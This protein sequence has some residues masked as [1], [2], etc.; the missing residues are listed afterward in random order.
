M[1]STPD[2]RRGYT[3]DVAT[4][5]FPLPHGRDDEGVLPRHRPVG[6]AL[7]DLLVLGPE[8]DALRPVLVDVAE[9]RALPAAERVVGDRDRYRHVDA[10][11]ADIDPRRELAGGVAVA[12]EDGDAVAIFVLGGEAD[13]FLEAVGADHL[14]YGPEN[15]LLVGAEARLHMVEEGWADE[16]ALLMAL[17]AE[18]ADSDD[19][20]AA[21]LLAHLDVAL[22]LG[23]VGGGDGRAVMGLGVGRDAD[24]QGADGRDQLLAQRIGGLVADRHH[25]RQRHAAL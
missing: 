1:A 19:Q 13:R 2:I 23:L 6:P 22:D 24:A 4:M 11:H 16:E 7:G 14:Q 3:S 12:G 15:L 10:D 8:A 9:A 18:A 17:E 21:F 25:H 5:Q 20:L